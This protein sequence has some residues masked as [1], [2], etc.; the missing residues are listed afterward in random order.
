MASF[1]L[2]EMSGS[3]SKMTGVMALLSSHI[4][5][6]EGLREYQQEC[7]KVIEEAQRLLRVK[8]A[9]ILTKQ[10]ELETEILQIEK[11]LGPDTSPK[12]SNMQALMQ[13]DHGT[14]RQREEEDE[15][16]FLLRGFS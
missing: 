3:A 6:L 9:E 8:Q 5:L 7:F 12:R 2:A 10:K 4:K 16:N 14:K 1:N 11:F 15:Q 13:G